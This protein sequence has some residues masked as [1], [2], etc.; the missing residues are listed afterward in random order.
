MLITR[1]WQGTDALYICRRKHKRVINILLSPRSILLQDYL[2]QSQFALWRDFYAKLPCQTPAFLHK[3]PLSYTSHQHSANYNTGLSYNMPHLGWCHPP[4]W[5]AQKHPVSITAIQECGYFSETLSYRIVFNDKN[6]V[7]NIRDAEKYWFN[8]IFGMSFMFP[9]LIKWGTELI[10]V[11][12]PKKLF[13]LQTSLVDEKKC[14]DQ[15]VKEQIACIF[16]CEKYRA[17]T[18]TFSRKMKYKAII[19]GTEDKVKIH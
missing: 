17:S 11:R 15:K 6:R 2:L 3:Q 1:R 7:S 14:T 19:V 4:I 18:I 5:P 8:K 13:I 16:Y 9:I 12:N 10:A